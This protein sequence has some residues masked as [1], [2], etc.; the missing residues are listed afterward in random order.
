MSGARG[1]AYKPFLDSEAGNAYMNFEVAELL[2]FWTEKTIEIDPTERER[3]SLGLL[4]E[5]MPEVIS[6]PRSN[7]K[8]EQKMGNG[9]EM[10]VTNLGIVWNLLRLS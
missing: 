4:I 2:K 1:I 10:L 7:M 9:N 6:V 8:L 3:P 5:K